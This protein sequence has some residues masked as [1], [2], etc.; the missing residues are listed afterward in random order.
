MKVVEHDD[1]KPSLLNNGYTLLTNPRFSVSSSEL[2][3]RRFY[4]GDCSSLQ[5]GTNTVATCRDGTPELLLFLEDF[6]WKGNKG[7]RE[8]CFFKDD[9]CMR[10]RARTPRALP[11][12][13]RQPV[14]SAGAS[15][16]ATRLWAISRSPQ[17][18]DGVRRPRC[19]PLSQ[20]RPRGPIRASSGPRGPCPPSPGSAG[21]C[22]NRTA[23]AGESSLVRSSQASSAWSRWV[24]ATPA[25]RFRSP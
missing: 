18:S 16:H 10:A 13:L 21:L 14:G 9:N 8:L 6:S 3:A 22:D 5:R 25:W 20:R 24:A 4:S 17:D 1:K 23:P 15:T 7:L 11:G 2:L 12:V 19:P